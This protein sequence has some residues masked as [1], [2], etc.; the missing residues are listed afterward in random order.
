[1]CKKLYNSKC[2]IKINFAER[3]GGQMSRKRREKEKGKKQAAG[4]NQAARQNQK[5]MKSARQK[6]DP[7]KW[8][9]KKAMRDQARYETTG[10]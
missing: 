5:Q 8:E 10:Q 2:N 9:R 1:M 7:A 4:Q 6:H 3:N